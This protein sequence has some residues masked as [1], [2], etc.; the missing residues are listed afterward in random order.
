MI[1]ISDGTNLIKFGTNRALYKANEGVKLKWDPNPA[2]DELT[3]TSN[4]SIMPTKWNKA[5]EGAWRMDLGR[6]LDRA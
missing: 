6:L 5:C 4:R 1:E 2:R 3:T